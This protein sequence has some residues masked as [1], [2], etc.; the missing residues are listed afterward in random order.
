MT[1]FQLRK[2]DGQ[3]TKD[4][5]GDLRKEWMNRLAVDT[6]VN[7]YCWNLLEIVKHPALTTFIWRATR[8]VDNVILTHL[9][10]KQCGWVGRV[11]A[12]NQR[13]GVWFPL[14]VIFF[15]V[16]GKLLILRFLC[17]KSL[18]AKW[19]KQASQWHE[20]YCH[21]LEVMSSNPTQVELGVRST[22]ALSGTWTKNILIVM[23]TWLS[24]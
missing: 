7:K 6:F 23:G 16:W 2:F 3:W 21:D 24:E 13:S 10:H 4:K 12:S 8:Y 1:Y 15:Q 11:R 22:A 9:L 19:L 14:V 18:M 20:M 5:E 17:K